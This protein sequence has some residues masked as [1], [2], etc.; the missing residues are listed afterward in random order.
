MARF[1]FFRVFFFGHFLQQRVVSFAAA[2]VAGTTLA[3]G[4]VLQ[5]GYVLAAV[6]VR[7]AP[8]A[9]LPPLYGEWEFVAGW[10]A[11]VVVSPPVASLSGR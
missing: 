2:A 11:A 3:N 7:A 4:G 9:V 6:L 1:I 5:Y 10:F 8:V